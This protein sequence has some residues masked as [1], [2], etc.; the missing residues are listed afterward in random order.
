[1]ARGSFREQVL[2]VRE[3]AIVAAALRLL[4]AKGF[5]LMTVDDVA[6]EVGIAKASVYKHFASKEALAAAAM[7]HVLELAGGVAEAQPAEAAALDKL[8]S[9]LRWALE[10]QLDGQMPALPPPASPLRAE[11]RASPRFRAALAPLN[12]RLSA[13]VQRA[14]ADGSLDAT[15][16]ADAVLHALYA[17][18]CDPLPGL[19]HAE[20]LGGGADA[21]QAVES[22]LR[23]G[24]DGLRAR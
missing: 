9:V 12:E 6:A 7:A 21:A 13:W 15:L 8:R 3:Q 5:D 16:P 17:R 2:R 23:I 19:L 1:M 18:A 20:G 24:I 22:W 10:R 4:A 14:Q 11:L